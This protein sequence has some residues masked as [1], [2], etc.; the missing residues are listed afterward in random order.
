MKESPTWS[1]WLP[2]LFGLIWLGASLTLLRLDFVDHVFKH[3][4]ITVFPAITFVC[5]FVVPSFYISFKI[6]KKEKE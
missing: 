3:Q 1:R 2:L 6:W 5:I 4:G